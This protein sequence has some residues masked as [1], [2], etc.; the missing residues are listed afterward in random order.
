MTFEFNF[1]NNKANK[2]IGYGVLG[3]SAPLIFIL[4]FIDVIQ[5]ELFTTL[6]IITALL[7]VGSFIYFLWKFQKHSRSKDR[8]EL[9]D[10]GFDSEFHGSIL[11]SE[12]ESISGFGVLGAPPPS[13]KIRLSS[14]KKIV[15]Y[16][17]SVKSRFNTEK[18]AEI[19]KEF[20]V[21]LGDRLAYYEKVMDSTSKNSFLENKSEVGVETLSKTTS[22]TETGKLSEQVK[23]VTKNHNRA[24]WTVPVVLVFAVLA[25]T[26]TCGEDYF[27]NKRDKEVQQI[28]TNSD[29]RH[30]QLMKESKK[31][32]ENYIPS[33]G[34][35]YLYTNDQDVEIK[36]LPDIP[37]NNTLNAT[38]VLA[39]AAQSKH[40]RNLIKHPD[41]TDFLTIILHPDQKIKPMAKSRLNSLDSTNTWLYLRF[42]DF[43]R[44]INSK[45]YQKSKVDSS[46]FV[47]LDIRTGIAIYEDQSIRQSLENSMI[48]LPM[49]LAQAKHSATFNIYLTGAEKDQVSD[50]LFEN[51]KKEL[52]A[53]L[54]E[55]EVDTTSFRR[56]I[57]NQS[58]N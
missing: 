41:S 56:K 42:T 14:E 3:L 21:A 55:V 25:F 22:S 40:L 16:L 54:H 8:I 27:E 13:M 28:F 9:K 15:W 2:Y 35:V 4:I 47:P 20:T 53:M 23:K 11:F 26:R 57:F 6:L 49:L 51:V 39:R 36:L 50:Q 43:N 44:Q 1:Q 5:S 19:F 33:L 29:I 10:D 7:G 45:P 32:L 46:T 34:A 48:G 24:I 58:K 31:T 52:Q 30:D 37:E 38:P 17:S 18:D 12:I